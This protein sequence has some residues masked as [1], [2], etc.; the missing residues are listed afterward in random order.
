[1]SNEKE[2][3]WSLSNWNNT[4]TFE[5]RLVLTFGD[6]EKV[7]DWKLY[8]NGDDITSEYGEISEIFEGSDL[9]KAYPDTFEWT[10]FYRYEHSQSAAG[11]IYKAT[12]Q[13]LGVDGYY[14]SW[15]GTDW[16]DRIVADVKAYTSYGLANSKIL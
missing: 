2:F 15:N 10:D 16:N 5:Y 8:S 4:E 7:S 1:M 12:N 6:D 3:T 9:A 14:D 13:F 11:I